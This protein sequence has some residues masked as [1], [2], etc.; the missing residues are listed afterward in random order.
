M[1]CFGSCS[2]SSPGSFPSQLVVAPSHPEPPRAPS[3]QPEG[4]YLA[5]AVASELGDEADVVVP[6]LNHLLADV[7][8]GADAA[9]GTRPPGQKTTGLEQVPA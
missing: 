6:D 1:Y 3:P 5:V 8:L 4:A 2:P 7:V 9:L